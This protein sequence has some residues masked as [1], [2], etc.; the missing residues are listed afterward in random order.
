MTDTAIPLVDLQGQHRSLW[1][2]LDAAIRRVVNRAQFI[3]GPE[4]EALEREVAAYAGVAHG[5]GVASGTDALTLALRACGVGPGDEV[6][7]TAF[8]FFATAGAIA[9]IGA[10][11][12]F[13]DIDPATYLLD[14]QRAAAAVTPRTKALVPVHLYGQACDMAALMS[15]ARARGLKVIEDCAQAIGAQDQGTPVGGFGDAA[16][17]SFFPSKNLGAFGDGGMVLTNEAALAAQV[18]LLRGHGS[19]E[20]YRH[21]ILGT[22]SRLDEL[23]AAVL[24]VKLRHLDAWN[25]ARCRLAAHYRSLLTREGLAALA[26]QE[27]PAGRHVYHL[28]TI[29]TPRREAVQ[30]ALGRQGIASRAYYPSTLPS[31]PALQSLAPAAAPCPAAEAAAREVLSLPM[32]PELPEAAVARIVAAVAAAAR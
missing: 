26:P 13:A 28:Y 31:Q 6:V 3:L 17:F 9:A 29:R 1:P 7:T 4:V 15:L 22:N 25:K 2:D 8:S 27:R 14:P 20:P 21:E 19:R 5:V 12:V 11:P 10:R 23:Q 32:Y 16:A 24:R 30:A 18:R